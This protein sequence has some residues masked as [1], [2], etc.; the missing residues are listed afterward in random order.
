MSKPLF[1]RCLELTGAFET[2]QLPPA[3]YGAS[4]GNFD[5]AGMSF[6]VIQFNLKSCTLQPIL[7]QMAS[8]YPAIVQAAFGKLL[9]ELQ[10]MLSTRSTQYQI[11]WAARRTVNS[12]PLL[13]EWREAF[14]K[15]GVTQECIAIQR[16]VAKDK[17][18]SNAVKMCQEYGLWSERG[19]ALMF[20]IAVQNGS[21]KP[22]I[23][24]FILADFKK[25]GKDLTTEAIEAERLKIIAN[26]RAEASNPK[27][28]ENVRRRKLLIAT[29]AGSANGVKADLEKDFGIKLVRA[30]V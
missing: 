9:S 12:R 28:V 8:Q 7:R 29:G 11:D 1:E 6:G 23:K 25:L 4:V 5:G 13:P 15:L 17:Y 27:W 26:R 24:A 2:S 14:R 21:I 10:T 18:Y 22:A 16:K 3:S 30:M 20:D 19:L